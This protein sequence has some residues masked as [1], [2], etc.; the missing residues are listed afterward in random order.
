M[1]FAKRRLPPHHNLVWAGDLPSDW[2][3]RLGLREAGWPGL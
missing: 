2:L 1:T 3:Q